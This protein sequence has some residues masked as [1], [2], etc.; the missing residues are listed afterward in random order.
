MRERFWEM[1]L[2]NLRPDEW[3]ALCD[4]CGKC[5][6]NKIEYEDTGEIAFT[7]VS[8]KLLDGQ[9]CQCSNYANRHQFVP[10]CVVLTPKKLKEIAWWLP[11]TCAYRLRTEGKPLYPWHYLISGDRESV[12]DAGISIRGRTVSELTVTEDDWDDYI[13]ED[14]A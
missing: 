2:K 3:E 1:P 9:T 12:H 8:C 4:G 7:C 10:D 14:L 11:A 6:L 5:C 13:I